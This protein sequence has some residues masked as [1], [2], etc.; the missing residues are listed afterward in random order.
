R[1]P[2]F[3]IRITVAPRDDLRGYLDSL[4]RC[5]RVGPSPLRH[6]LAGGPAAGDRGLSAPAGQSPSSGDP[7]R[8]DWHRDGSGLASPQVA[9]NR[10]QSAALAAP[11][12][13]LPDPLPGTQ[14]TENGEPIAAPRA[15]DTDPAC[16][17]AAPR[18]APATLPRVVLHGQIRPFG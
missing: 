4:E 14:S 6:G 15:A 8:V 1:I 11:C 18:G 12:R 2:T 13:G 9:G 17:A 16:G 10:D 5:G 7:G 3:R